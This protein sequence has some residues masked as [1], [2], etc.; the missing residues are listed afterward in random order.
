MKRFTM[1]VLAIVV[2]MCVSC[3]SASDA[4]KVLKSSGFSEIEIE[5]Y[6]FFGCGEDDAFHTKFCAKNP[7]GVRVCGV[8]CSGWFKGGTLRFD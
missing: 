8:V 4:N 2:T 1:V 7:K 6:T 5:G 3:S